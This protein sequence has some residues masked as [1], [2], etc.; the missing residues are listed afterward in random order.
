MVVIR[1][2]RSGAK[3]SPFYHVVVANSRDSRDGRFIERLGFYN[4]MARGKETRLSIDQ[5]RIAYWESCGAQSTERVTSLVK[6]INKDANINAPAP[7]KAEQKLAQVAESAK[8]A[9]VTAEEAKKAAE[10]SE[11]ATAE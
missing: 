9:R 7:T 6:K 10:S 2:A 5:E 8:A 4:P 11:E 1:L 3:K